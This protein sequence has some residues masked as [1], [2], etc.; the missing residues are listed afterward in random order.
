MAFKIIWS[1]QAHDDLRDVVT[2]IAALICSQEGDFA[3]ETKPPVWYL[4]HG[5]EML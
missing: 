5:Y 2:F 3:L 1:K 4:G